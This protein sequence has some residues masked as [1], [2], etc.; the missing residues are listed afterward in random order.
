MDHGT[1][2]VSV[3][4]AWHPC[5]HKGQHR[6]RR[7][8]AGFCRKSSSCGSGSSSRGASDRGEE[9]KGEKRE[10]HCSLS[11]YVRFVSPS[12]II[13]LITH[14]K[15]SDQEQAQGGA[16]TPSGGGRMG[17][18]QEDTEGNKG[19]AQGGVLTP[20][21]GGR[22]GASQEDTEGNKGQAQGGI[23]TPGRG[24]RRGASQEDAEGNKGE[25]HFL[26][27]TLT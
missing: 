24:G 14:N 18:S 12:S 23:L 5:L 10:F 1:D 13:F 11:P 19:Q 6:G 21:G 4:E 26:L 16:L 27:S 25:F 15:F 22:R 7:G 20:G 17:A 2:A 8:G 9:D 3:Q